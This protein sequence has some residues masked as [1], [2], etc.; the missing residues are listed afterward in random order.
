MPNN[1]TKS[2]TKVLSKNYISGGKRWRKR[3]KPKTYSV[4]MTPEIADFPWT[5]LEDGKPVAHYPE[6]WQAETAKKAME[7]HSKEFS[8]EVN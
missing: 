5:V 4:K 7:A 1:G 2:L 8:V 3:K 6:K